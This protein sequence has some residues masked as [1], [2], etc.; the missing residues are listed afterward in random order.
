M[1]E[2]RRTYYEVLS[3]AIDD[4]DEHGYDS[5]ERVAY[6]QMR[7]KEAAERAMGSAADMERMLRDAMI[8]IYRRQVE[9]GGVLRT[10]QGIGRFT[11]ERVRPQ[12]RAELDRRILAAADLIRLNRK[13]AI[14]KTLRRF[15]GFSTSIP[16]GGAAP[17]QGTKAKADCRKALKQLPFVERRVLIDQGHKLNASISEVLANDGGA[18]GGYWV[19]HFRQA[20]YDYR[21]DHKERDGKFYLVKDSWAIQQ[22]LIKKGSHEYIEDVTRPAEEPFCLP[23]DA[24]VDFFNDIEKAY[25]RPYDGDM[26]TLVLSSGKTMR[27]TPNHPILTSDG[28]RAI[29]LLKEG[30]HVIEVCEKSIKSPELDAHET[31]LPIS[32][33]FSTVQACSRNE[34]LRGMRPQFHG[35][36]SE[37]DIDVVSLTRP[38]SDHLMTSLH[39]GLYE[40]FLSLTDIL[41]LSIRSVHEGFD[42]LLT[43]SDR[44]MSVSTGF[45]PVPFNDCVYR[46]VG[47]DRLPYSVEDR[48]TGYTE[49]R[50]KFFG[51]F[52]RRIPSPNLDIIKGYLLNT[53][54]T[55]AKV[56]PSPLV[57]VPEV[58]GSDAEGLGNRG[59]GPSL[60]TKIVDVIR[61]DRGSFSGH[62]YNL[63]TTSGWYAVNG[64]ITHNCRCF[65]RFVYSV[66]KLPEG[67]LTKKGEAKLEEV[68]TK[69]RAA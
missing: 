31:L 69:M 7:I 50:G 66:G 1:T 49:K 67:T 63:Q 29:G 36:G 52:P 9:K 14:E 40:F 64:I 33:L 42:R 30:D 27:A 26:I 16:K 51:G 61:V 20:G 17:G 47:M 10:H 5:A 58:H 6:W 3:D 43:S 54:K 65:Y 19:S 37:E 13:E 44:I 23:G 2:K 56:D 12:L 68:R 62:V 22:G 39:E 57:P 35:D 32:D 55:G 48:W 25:R 59:D 45:F 15:A 18:L 4:L 53:A 24:P 28:W 60:L 21:E 46:A 34:I 8:A 38:L 11:L 41:G